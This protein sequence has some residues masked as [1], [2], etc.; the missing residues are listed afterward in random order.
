M[1]KCKEQGPNMLSFLYKEATQISIFTHQ[2]SSSSSPSCTAEAA[3]M[4]K[5][6]VMVVAMVV[7]A[8]A[9]LPVYEPLDPS[10]LGEPTRDGDGALMLKPVLLLRLLQ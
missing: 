10:E 5:V 6:A 7:D 4:Q 1:R 2:P 3:R 8:G 9:G